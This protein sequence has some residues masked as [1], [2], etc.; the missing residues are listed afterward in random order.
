VQKGAGPEAS[1]PL[2][3]AA[4]PGAAPQ[5]VVPQAPGLQP[6]APQTGGYAAPAQAAPAQAVAVDPSLPFEPRVGARAPQ[7]ALTTLDGQSLN[8]DAL[9]GRPVVISYWAT[10]CIPCQ[11]ELPILQKLS[12]E[13]SA[14]GLV[15]LTVN[16]IDQDSLDKVQTMLAE[17]GLTLPVLLDEGGS[18]A[19][20]YQAMF[21]PTTFYIDPS[22]VIRFIKLG[23]SSE[24][25]LRTHVDGLVRG[26]L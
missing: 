13:Y 6:G 21:F 9:V 7:F 11:Q 3:D 19:S 4:A 24:Q 25:D 23:D 2:T 8:M 22:G 18:F 10:W 26:D 20:A 1:A 5:A 17:K 14:S 12:Q 15:V 16:A